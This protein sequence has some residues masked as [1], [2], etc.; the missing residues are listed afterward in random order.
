KARGVM[1]CELEGDALPVMRR[2]NEEGS[3]EGL[4]PTARYEEI[5][6]A[7]LSRAPPPEDFT[8]TAFGLPEPDFMKNQPTATRW[9]LWGAL[10]GGA[11]LVL[12]AVFSWLRQRARR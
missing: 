9:W 2:R 6:K 3:V 11:L 12:G 10:A 7:E 4:G 8:L 5:E 1:S